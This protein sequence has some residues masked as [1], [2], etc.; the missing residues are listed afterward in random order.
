MLRPLRFAF[1]FA[2]AVVTGCAAP[3]QSTAPLKA[4]V[5]L[6]ASP[7]SG[8]RFDF[9]VTPEPSAPLSLRNAAWL[10]FLSA[11]EYTHANVLG[12]MLAQLGFANAD[13]PDDAAWDSCTG[14]LRRLR[15][16]EKKHEDELAAVL[17][18]EDLRKVARSLLP[19]GADWGSCVRPFLQDPALRVDAYPAASFQDH[20]VREVHAGS[21]LQFFSAGS[22]AKDG[23]SFRD[24]ST[25]VVFARHRELPIAILA[26]RGTEPSQRVDVLVDLK[27][28]KTDLEDHKWPA[29]WGSAHIGFVG[30]FESI[31][32]LLMKKLAELEGTGVKL[33]ITGHSL[34][35][36]LATLA[37][38]RLM[39]ARDEGMKL[40]LAGV[41]TFGSP[42][43]GDKEFAATFEAEAEK[44]GVRVIRF[45]NG[46]DVVTRIPGALIEYEHVGTLAH[47]LEGSLTIAPSPEPAYDASSA[48]DHNSSGFD[49]NG[50]PTSGYYRRIHELLEKKTYPELD[51]CA[52]PAK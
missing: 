29:P 14:D 49:A 42:R 12:P 26:F 13:V 20:L 37:A 38:A 16:A 17:G 40:E 5:P 24:A 33:Y 6:D 41:A 43:V 18:K 8:Q 4:A 35:G 2:F 27:V 34:G 52:E 39:R 3:T 1:A 19:D 32:P 23:K 15:E 9:C 25:Q 46:D 22:I 11:N 45:R 44:Q 50:A 7:S 48:A 51:R 21:Y 30:A 10:S 47:L 36:A 31:E 28:F